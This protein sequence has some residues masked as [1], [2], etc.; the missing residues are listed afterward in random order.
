MDRAGAEGPLTDAVGAAPPAR[1]PYVICHMMASID[2]RI[3]ADGWPE[4][5]G[6]WDE[7]ERTGS[8]FEADAWMCGRITMEHF[9]AGV[10]SADE[11]AGEAAR[12]APDAA[13]RADF[14][15]PGEH[16]SC[17]IAVDPSGRLRWESNEIHGDH[18]V[19][20]LT[21]RVS[22]E[23]LAGLRAVGVSYIV[24]G[25]GAESEAD[26]ALALGK[27][28]SAFGIRTLLLEGGGGINGS[29]LRDG[30]IDEVSLLVAPVADGG[31]GAPSLFDVDR[32]APGQS[33]RRLALHSVERRADGV[34]WLRYRLEGAGDPR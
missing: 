27:V 32:P 34:L 30:L 4:L 25:A 23:Y 17:A 8:T 31:V 10:R 11:V 24:A 6:G 2:G 16:P 29:M 26:L 1:R 28:A 14:V 5:G 7:Y 20:V 3:V 21:E 19:V 12:R 18:V 9:A 13:A 33:A 22:D 15:A